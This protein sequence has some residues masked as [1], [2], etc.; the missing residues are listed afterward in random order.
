LRF[1][2]KVLVGTFLGFPLGVLSR[3][4]PDGFHLEPFGVLPPGQR[5]EPLKVLGRTFLAKRAAPGAV[6]TWIGDCPGN[7][8]PAVD[9]AV[10]N[11]YLGAASLGWLRLG[12]SPASPLVCTTGGHT[13]HSSR[14]HVCRR[15]PQRLIGC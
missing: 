4:L 9:P 8:R 2:G 14:R 3:T 6:S 5:L 13:C 1:L 10:G 12:V 15:P 7:T 11:G